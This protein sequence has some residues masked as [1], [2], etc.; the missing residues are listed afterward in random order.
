M[1]YQRAFPFVGTADE[2]WHSTAPEVRDFVHGRIR[3]AGDS[4]IARMEPAAGVLGHT[5]PAPVVAPASAERSEHRG[6]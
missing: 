2:I 4:A 6:A 1:L 5:V 3:R